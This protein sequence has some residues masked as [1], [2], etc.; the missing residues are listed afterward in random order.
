MPL[1]ETWRSRDRAPLRDA[2]GVR[3]EAL[4]RTPEAAFE[5]R[6]TSGAVGLDVLKLLLSELA[7]RDLAALVIAVGRVVGVRDKV[8]RAPTQLADEDL[9]A[10]TDVLLD[11]LRRLGAGAQVAEA[12]LCGQLALDRRRQRRAAPS[13]LDSRPC[14]RQQRDECTYGRDHVALLLKRAAK[15]AADCRE[16]NERRGPDED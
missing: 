13:R 9:G 7:D 1:D 2:R 14:R 16:R 4:H 3:V 6:R 11:G 5:V 8:S 15:R 10:A 12:D